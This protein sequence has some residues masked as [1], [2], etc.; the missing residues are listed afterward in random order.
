MAIEARDL[1]HTHTHTHY[2]MAASSVAR[3]ARRVP[4]VG[5]CL[6]ELIGGTPASEVTFDHVPANVVTEEGDRNLVLNVAMVALHVHLGKIDAISW[7]VEVEESEGLYNVLVKYPKNTC[8]TDTQLT[9]VR[10]VNTWRIREVWTQPEDDCSY[11]NATVWDCHST[12]TFTRQDVVLLRHIVDND[13]A[14]GH[15][16][17]P[18]PKGGGAERKRTRR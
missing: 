9:T 16:H 1:R 4:R 12:P 2:Y 15:V 11:I 10:N 13:D 5:V 18:V 6:C 8:F 3:V 14:D 7:S 17:L